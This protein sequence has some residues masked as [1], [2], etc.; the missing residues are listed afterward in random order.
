LFLHP[1]PASLT[2]ENGGVWLRIG[3]AAAIDLRRGADA[4]S[5]LVRT[6]GTPGEAPTPDR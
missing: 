4:A 5:E 3:A 1:Q 6:I 2:V